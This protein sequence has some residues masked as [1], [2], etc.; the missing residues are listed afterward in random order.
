MRCV[1]Q[2][3]V[4]ESTGEPFCFYSLESKYLKVRSFWPRGD[5]MHYQ[6]PVGRLGGQRLR[7][8]C[9]F[10]HSL[11]ANRFNQ[12]KNVAF[13]LALCIGARAGREK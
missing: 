7:A 4:Y 3:R 13:M 12:D 6:H 11:A 10:G 5:I 8:N 9:R 1:S 2:C